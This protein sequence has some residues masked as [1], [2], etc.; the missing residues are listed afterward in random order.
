[1]RK[2]FSR[3]KC[4]FQ[5]SLQIKEGN[6]SILELQSDNAV[7]FETQALTVEAN[8]PIQIIDAPR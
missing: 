5:T 1:M 4:E 2:A 6:R 8:S 3:P 7:G